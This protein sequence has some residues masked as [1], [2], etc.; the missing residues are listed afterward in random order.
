MQTPFTQFIVVQS[1]PLEQWPPPGVIPAA[2]QVPSV[3]DNPWQSPPW[4]HISPAAA[5]PTQMPLIQ[6]KLAHVA[7]TEHRP[8]AGVV[9]PLAQVPLEQ[10]RLAQSLPVEH[11]PPAGA[12]PPLSHTPVVQLELAQSSPAEHRS[13]AALLPAQMP[14]TQ[15]MLTHDPPTVHSPPPTV[16][17]LPTASQEP[18][19]QLKLLH[20]LSSLHPPPPDTAPGSSQTPFVELK[21]S[22]PPPPEFV[23]SPP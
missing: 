1:L 11:S 2:S 20:T 10:L 9:P 8:P 3:Q 17:P 22:Q 16:F 6:F 15:L 12:A 4:T 13:P 23:P 18:S 14:P 7:P 19:V 5:L 21:L